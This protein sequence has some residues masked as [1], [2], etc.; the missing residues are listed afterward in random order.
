MNLWI[1]LNLKDNGQEISRRD[2]VGA[3]GFALIIQVDE[4]GGAHEVYHVVDQDGWT[5]VIPR[6]EV[7]SF[8]C[9]VR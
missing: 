5:V 2:F 7:E 4:R 8:N 9:V 1:T 3:Q 6:H